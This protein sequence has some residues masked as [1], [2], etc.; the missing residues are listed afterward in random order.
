MIVVDH[1][2][3]VSVCLDVCSRHNSKNADPN[4]FKF[5]TVFGLGEVLDI[6]VNCG[7]EVT[8]GQSVEN[9]NIVGWL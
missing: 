8:E 3:V 5:Y 6:C 7:Q 4:K 2:F 1:V 9:Y